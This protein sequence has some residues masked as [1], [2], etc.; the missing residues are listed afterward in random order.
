MRQWWERGW[1]GRYLLSAQ[2]GRGREGKQ[3]LERPCRITQNPVHSA[4]LFTSFWEWY[5][6]FFLSGFACLTVLRAEFL[7][8]P[9]A[10]NSF[11]FPIPHRPGGGRGREGAGSSPGGTSTGQWLLRGGEQCCWG[12]SGSL[13]LGPARASLTCPVLS[14]GIYGVGKAALHPPA[15]AVL[16]HTP[17]GATQTIAWVGKGIVYDTGG[18]SMKGKVRCGAGARAG[19]GGRAPSQASE[20]GARFLG[21]GVGASMGEAVGPSPPR[22]RRFHAHTSDRRQ[23]KENLEE[24]KEGAWGDAHRLHDRLR[25]SKRMLSGGSHETF[26]KQMSWLKGGEFGPRSQAP[27]SIAGRLQ[28]PE[29][30]L[31]AAPSHAQG[32]ALH[33]EQGE[34]CLHLLIPRAGA[35]GL[36][37]APGGNWKR[38][39]SHPG[40]GAFRRLSAS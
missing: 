8:S 2:R 5:N 35:P 20:E 7:C 31:R 30:L 33:Q 13:L 12:A 1:K 27:G 25:S 15:L 38:R 26:G 23:E 39:V 3:G 19:P 11:T 4:V 17:D 29:S 14:L 18:L 34:R 16:S 9:R 37:W 36:G 24:K 10:V 32:P 40:E 28:V 22:G 21:L 6:I